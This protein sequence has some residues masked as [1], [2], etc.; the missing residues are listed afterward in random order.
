MGK[1]IPGLD[2][3]I[4][5]RGK[6]DGLEGWTFWLRRLGDGREAL[7]AERLGNQGPIQGHRLEI[8]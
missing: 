3:G 6:W 7:A 1:E 4:G 8:G 2:S 5:A